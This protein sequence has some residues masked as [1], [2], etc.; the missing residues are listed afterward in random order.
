MICSAEGL[1]ERV[2]ST[3]RA[4]ACLI[5]LA[6]PGPALANLIVV[7]TE[8]DGPVNVDGECSLR[9]AVT[10]ALLDSFAGSPDCVNG[11]GADSISFANVY[12]STPRQI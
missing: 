4:V 8:F 5:C 7:T 9:E 12:F 11:S 2:G 6:I 3:L 1:F 10:N